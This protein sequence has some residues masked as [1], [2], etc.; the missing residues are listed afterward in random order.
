MSSGAA[1][2]GGTR[3]RAGCPGRRAVVP[4]VLRVVSTQAPPQQPARRLAARVVPAAVDAGGEAPTGWQLL[5][6][7][8]ASSRHGTQSWALLQGGAAAGR[9]A[10]PEVDVGRWW[11][12][13]GARRAGS[14]RRRR[15]CPVG[16]GGVQ[17]YV[18]GQR[19]AATARGEA[20]ADNQRHPCRRARRPQPAFA[21]SA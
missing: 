11:R 7:Q 20:Q 18:S 3:G 4:A 1:G 12:G 21:D 2:T 19:A 16:Q 17:V 10:A 6:G 8:C 14:R 15:S 13:R 9:V 5:A